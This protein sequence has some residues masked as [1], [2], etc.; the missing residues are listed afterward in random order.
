MAARAIWKGI[1]RVGEIS[2]PV[3]LYGAVEEKTLHFRLLHKKDHTPVRQEMVHPETGEI[4]PA[5]AICHGYATED[6]EMVI[7]TATELKG[8]EPEASRQIEIICFLPNAAIDHRWFERPYYLGPDGDRDS[9]FALA[10]ALDSAGT[11]GLVRWS[12]RNKEYF[13][14]LRLQGGY[15]VLITLRHAEEVVQLAELARPAGREIDKRELAMAEQLISALADRFDPAQYR[16]EYRARV[17][18]LIAGKASGK[19]IPL[20]K[21]VPKKTTRDLKKALAE[22]LQIARERQHA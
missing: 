21:A 11:E 20:R 15:P 5:E 16:D 18:G 22:S 19:I 3:K 10:A 8:L 13:G 7:L 4:V 17:L 12:M 14:V 1:I 9:Y 6:G 2:V